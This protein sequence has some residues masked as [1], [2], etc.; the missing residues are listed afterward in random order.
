MWTTR[1]RTSLHITE[2]RGTTTGGMLRACLDSVSGRIGKDVARL[3]A[4]DDDETSG[5]GLLAVVFCCFGFAA[6]VVAAAFFFFIL[7]IERDVTDERPPKAESL[8]LRRMCDTELC[9]LMEAL[10]LD[11]LQGMANGWLTLAPRERE[12]DEREEA[13]RRDR[14]RLRGSGMRSME[15]WIEIVSKSIAPV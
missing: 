12:A 5:L 9:L 4:D 3:I 15:I 1:T 10:R 8:R 14:L 11:F 2:R 13:R 6:A 7:F